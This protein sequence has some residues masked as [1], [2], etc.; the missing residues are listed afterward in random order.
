MSGTGRAWSRRIVWLVTR[1][2]LLCAAIM[3]AEMAF[4]L[5][6]D[7]VPWGL[8]NAQ[9]YFS[10]HPDEI[11]LLMPAFGFAQGD[12]N[13]HFFN[14]GT[15][16][17]YLVGIPA[18]VFD[19]VPGG[20]HFPDNLR[21]LY[22]WARMTSVWL[23]GATIPVLY[24]ALRRS[25]RLVSWGSAGL[26]AICPLHVVHSSYA[27]VDV[28]ATFWITVAFLL[29]LS[30]AES[31]SARRGM[32]AGAAVGLAAATKYNAGLFIVAV[33]A[34]PLLAPP[35][36]WS[37]RW[38]LGVV[39]GALIGFMAG[40]PF[41]WTREFAQGVLFEISHAARG[42]TPA[43][44][45]TGTGWEYHLFRGLP[46]GLGFSLLACAL[47]GA[48]VALRTTDRAARLSLF[49]CLL[50][51][52]AI[53]FG[54]ERFIRYL[55]PLA[56]FLVALAAMGIAW[57]YRLPRRFLLRVPALALL[58]LVGM[59]TFSYVIL[60]VPEAVESRRKDDLWMTV[61]T[62]PRDRAWDAIAPEVLGTATPKRVG[63]TQSPWYFTPPVAPWN[64]GPLFR[65]QFEAWN[66]QTGRVVITG[67]DAAKLA[68]EKPYFFFISDLEAMDL[69]RLGNPEVKEFARTEDSTYS[70]HTRFER[71][72][73]A[74]A[75][76]FPSRKLA[77]PDWLY[78]SPRISLGREPR[79]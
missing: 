12:W 26:L 6:A 25:G 35:R 22:Q 49:W 40:C 56:P 46:T 13:P 33:I 72:A 36:A 65:D 38:F 69:V 54:K 24:L 11:F 15:L 31:P 7:A 17:I 62:D 23:G 71:P 50:Y 44:V 53:G 28:A 42:G 20:S 10:Y 61:V 78:R 74:H 68:A 9:H 43:F 4:R 59:H 63:L 52:S 51:L 45:N 60:L 19:V 3:I 79:P 55:V 48:S 29:A 1:L 73:P 39:A 32:A 30:G 16:Y 64:S 34:C 2:L 70:R 27:T 47:I 37:R 41:F 14:Y 77:P 5:R 58:V 76:L 21:P 18:V 75:W 8:P 66:L 67:W 57:L